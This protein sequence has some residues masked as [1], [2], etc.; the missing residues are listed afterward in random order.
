MTRLRVLRFRLRA[1]EAGGHPARRPP[2]G[3]RRGLLVLVGLALVIAGVVG[4]RP[5]GSSRQPPR[6][7]KTQATFKYHF[8]SVPQMLATAKVV[9]EGKV[10]DVGRGRRLGATQQVK[11]I[12]I[13]PIKVWRGNVQQDPL[14]VEDIGWE[15]SPDPGEGE[16]ELIIAGTIQP[17]VG[18]HGVFFLTED[19]GALTFMR[20]QGIYLIDV[21]QVKDTGRRDPF[22]RRVEMMTKT[23]LDQMLQES[24]R[25]VKLG[26]VSPKTDS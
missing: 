22:I 12:R 21:G 11:E 23:Q 13:H 3:L 16:K 18:D 5:L 2:C 14:V 6:Q 4:F 17:K 9:L 24:V 1:N 7:Y 19:Y 20:N 26:K 8:D 25:Q 15:I 10:V